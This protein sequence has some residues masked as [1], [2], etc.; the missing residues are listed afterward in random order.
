MRTNKL[1]SNAKKLPAFF[2][3]LTL[4]AALFSGCEEDPTPSLFDPNYTSPRPAP[5]IAGI[6]PPD[7]A[8]A[9]IGIVVIDGSNFSAIKEENS[10]YFDGQPGEVLEASTT[11]LRVKVPNLVKDAISLK[12]AVYKADKFSNIISYKLEAAVS[13]VEGFDRDQAPWAA[14]FD[15][16]GNMYVSFVNTNVSS[17]SGVL[18]FA[19]DGTRSSYSPKPSGTPT[20]YSALKVGPGGFLYG[21]TI[22]RRISQIPVGGGAAVN[23]VVIPNTAVRLYDF[24]FDRDGNLWA[25]G[26][27]TDIYRV[28]P[29]KSIQAFPFAANVRSVRLFNDYIY[30]AGNRGG[31][32]KIWRLPIVSADQVG[33]EEEYFDFSAS[34]YGAGGA[35][36]FAITFAADGDMYLGTEAAEAII[37]VHPDRSAEP[38]YPGLFQPKS[39]NFGWDTG[40]FLYAI[41]EASGGSEQALVKINLL[42][43]SAPYY[44]RGDL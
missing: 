40:Q 8:F 36:I 43:N 13:E 1:Q 5:V 38:L 42:K 28:K 25:G 12:I 7:Q 3:A 20:R 21:L 19:T 35:G 11:Q 27:N 34:A 18:K 29:D 26:N 22:E 6:T 23:W 2:A 4:L 44:G 9:G 15:A 14:T 10:V 17:Q 31:S 41:R 16:Q 24:D 33:P 32:E 30:L 37:V 39:L